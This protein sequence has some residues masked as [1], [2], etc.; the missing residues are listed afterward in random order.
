M[1]LCIGL[2]LTQMTSFVPFTASIATS[3]GVVGGI[4]A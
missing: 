4:T 2:I 1:T 3:I